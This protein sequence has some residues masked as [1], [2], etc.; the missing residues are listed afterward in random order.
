MRVLSLAQEE[1]WR[2][3]WQPTFQC[4]CWRI[5]WMEEPGELQSMRSHSWTR[6]QRLSMHTCRTVCPRVMI[7]FQQLPFKEQRAET[8]AGPGTQC[9]RRILIWPLP[10]GGTQLPQLEAPAP[11]PPVA[12]AGTLA[13]CPALAGL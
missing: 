11:L 2:R 4:S 9:C 6:L 12:I 7:S 5:P 1:P 8:R 10:F 13:C 3:A